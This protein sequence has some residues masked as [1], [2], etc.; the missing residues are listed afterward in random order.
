MPECPQ[1][2]DVGKFVTDPYR[3][4]CKIL[5]CE[6]SGAQFDA[7]CNRYPGYKQ[8]EIHKKKYGD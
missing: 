6:I 2:K 5:G 3:P 1:C 8:C 4:F 7:Y